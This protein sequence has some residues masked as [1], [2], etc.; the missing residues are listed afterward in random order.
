MNP[1]KSTG[2]FLEETDA[3]GRRWLTEILHG[4]D[5]IDE[6][7]ST[8]GRPPWSDSPLDADAAADRP[9]FS[10]AAV[11]WGRPVDFRHD[12]EYLR[13]FRDPAQYYALPRFE[14]VYEIGPIVDSPKIYGFAGIAMKNLFIGRDSDVKDVNRR[15]DIARGEI[16]GARR[17]PKLK[18]QVTYSRDELTKRINAKCQICCCELPG[19]MAVAHMLCVFMKFYYGDLNVYDQE[20]RFYTPAIDTYFATHCWFCN[21]R[22]RFVMP[23]S[24]QRYQQYLLM[25]NKCAHL[26]AIAL[27]S[28]AQRIPV[29]EPSYDPD[30]GRKPS[31]P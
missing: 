10:T 11:Y 4:Q 21:A 15:V 26:H 12:P 20:T 1:R 18:A 2:I 9:L 14:Q 24:R 29:P 16:I 17:V 23:T 13:I 25:C 22:S 5:A 7:F 31:R 30:E 27:P 8:G 28:L 19:A 6:Y 3:S